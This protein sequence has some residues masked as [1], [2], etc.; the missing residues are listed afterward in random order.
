MNTKEWTTVVVVVAAS[1]I[2]ANLTGNVIR[3]DNN[4]LGKY[5]LYTKGE[6]YNKTQVDAKVK[7][8]FTSCLPSS[9]LSSDE[10]RIQTCNR[11]GKT[12]LIG[13]NFAGVMNTTSGTII[14]LHFKVLN[15]DEKQGIWSGPVSSG[16]SLD[17]NSSWIC[18]KL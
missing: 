5:Q 7:Q 17:V 13:T 3:Q 11:E 10:T 15:C 2:T 12:C 8:V 9:G 1:L 18:Y 16:L 6:L 4:P 14:P